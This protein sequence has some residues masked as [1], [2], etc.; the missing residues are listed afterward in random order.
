[1]AHDYVPSN[2]MQFNQWFLTLRDY[3]IVNKTKWSYIPTS[4]IN[5]LGLMDIF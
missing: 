2:M 5:E 1:M 3:V 4:A